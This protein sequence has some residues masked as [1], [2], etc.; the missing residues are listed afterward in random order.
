MSSIVRLFSS[1]DSYQFIYRCNL[2][3][4]EYEEKSTSRVGCIDWDRTAIEL[5]RLNGNLWPLMSRL[6]RSQHRS[7]ISPQVMQQASNSLHHAMVRTHRIDQI[8]GCLRVV[9]PIARHRSA[10][11]AIVRVQAALVVNILPRWPGIVR[12]TESAGW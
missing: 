12:V 4:L 9:V 11:R 1:A 5:S 7:P 6:S 10:R 3:G 2:R 8:R